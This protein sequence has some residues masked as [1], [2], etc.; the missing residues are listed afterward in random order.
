MQ[1][2]AFL[3]ARPLFSSPAV[4][5]V[6]TAVLALDG[7]PSIAGSG[8]V[9]LPSAAEVRT[10]GGTEHG[11]PL[12]GHPDVGVV[13][14][15]RVWGGLETA[16]REDK[17]L[18]EHPTNRYVLYPRDA[19]GDWPLDTDSGDALG[20]R[21]TDFWCSCLFST[22]LPDSGQS[23][24]EGVSASTELQSSSL[25]VVGHPLF[26]RVLFERFL[27]PNFCNSFPSF[28]FA[29]RTQ[30]LAPASCVAVRVQ[31]GPPHIPLSRN[32]PLI[33]GVDLQFGSR[34]C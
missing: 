17:S 12:D 21:L 7:H 11:M 5:A 15:E 19:L 31:F 23:T 30:M 6:Q 1:L 20:L 32:P 33:A 27:D 24:P 4:A 10:S 22:M 26:Y 2:Q 28:S 18:A 3:S 9:L 16:F 34:L 13:L 14:S 29:L 25:V 8:L